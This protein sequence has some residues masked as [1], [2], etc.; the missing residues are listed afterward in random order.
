MI[1]EALHR[2]K[3]PPDIL[4]SDCEVYGLAGAFI[5]RVL[6]HYD[7]LLRLSP[8]KEPCEGTL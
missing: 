6:T 1:E 2:L 4:P 8:T 7:F 5:R 3:R